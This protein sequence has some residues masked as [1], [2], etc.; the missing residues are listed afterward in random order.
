MKLKINKKLKKM[1][2][3]RNNN[4][5]KNYNKKHKLLINQILSKHNKTNNNKIINKPLLLRI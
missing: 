4:Q 3:F 2:N 1:L 5:S